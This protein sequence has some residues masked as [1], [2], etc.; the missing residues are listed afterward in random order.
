MIKKL[1]LLLF[2]LPT[3]SANATLL[4]FDD[5]P[6]GSNPNSFGSM[7]VYQG[8]NFSP[9]LFWIDVADTSPWPYGAH[10]GEF[11]IFNNDKVGTGIITEAGGDDFTFDGLWAKKWDT[12]IDS[13][14]ADSLFG[15]LSGYN[16]GSEVWKVATGLNGSYEFY[17]AQLGLIDELHLGFGN[18]FLVDDIKLNGSSIP[19]VPVGSSIP[20]VPVPAAVWLF[21]TA[22][23]GL[24]GFAKRRKAA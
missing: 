13:G 5:I 2:L 19:A 21:G 1:T 7:P 12:R 22:M 15:S 16:N 6:G 18:N 3:F 14:G 4:T 20:A 17:G 8:F 10:S 23:I 24:F 9:N 11:G